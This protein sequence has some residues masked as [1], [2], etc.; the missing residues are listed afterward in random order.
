[1]PDKIKIEILED[2]ML[3]I[4]TDSIS[5]ANHMNADLFLKMVE[6]LAGKKTSE[7]R[8]VKTATHTHGNLVHTH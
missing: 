1:M 8:K 3:S 4:E 7:K 6:D 5:G 2:G